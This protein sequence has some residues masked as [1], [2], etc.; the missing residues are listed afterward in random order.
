MTLAHSKAYHRV[1]Q[2]NFIGQR[3]AE[4]GAMARRVLLQ[5]QCTPGAISKRLGAAARHHRTLTHWHEH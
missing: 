1:S 4:P 5:G 2:D 3:F